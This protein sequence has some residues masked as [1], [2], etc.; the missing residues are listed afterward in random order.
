[1]PVNQAQLIEE[2]LVQPLGVTQQAEAVK[3][4]AQCLTTSAFAPVE[5]V[6]AMACV[7]AA[8]HT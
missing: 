1:M 4:C 3:V 6:L 2:A 5:R 8:V 7:S